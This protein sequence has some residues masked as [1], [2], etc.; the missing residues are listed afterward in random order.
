MEMIN[1]LRGIFTLEVALRMPDA[2]CQRSLLAG[3]QVTRLPD[4]NE[5]A[6]FP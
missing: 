6:K 4:L 1:E 3:A 5:L 2:I